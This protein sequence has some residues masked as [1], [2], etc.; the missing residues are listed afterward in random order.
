MK[1]KL[2]SAVVTAMKAKDKLKLETYR[3]ALT[4]IQYEEMQ[5]KVE[6]L[7]EADA[8]AILKSEVKKRN[9]SLEFEQKANRADEV[10]KLKLEISYLEEF[11]PQQISADK[12]RDILTSY[13]TQE[14]PK[15]MGEVMKYLKTNFEGQYD[16]KLASDLAKEICG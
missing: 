11:L 10:E 8:V 2:K 14:N 13:K 3:A 12:L 7:P 9:D 1:A 15:N 6:E 4:A 5:K 16:G